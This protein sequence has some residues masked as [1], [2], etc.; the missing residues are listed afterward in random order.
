MPVRLFK[1]GECPAYGLPVKAHT[2]MR[3]LNHI[4]VIVITQKSRMRG[5]AV[6]GE[7]A[8]CQ[9]QAKNQSALPS[10]SESIYHIAIESGFKQ[11]ASWI[12]GT[13]KEKPGSLPGVLVVL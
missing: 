8:R 7:S 9:Q 10:G 12:V 3:I 11:G 5:A 4:A 1:R 2:H 6:K 13:K